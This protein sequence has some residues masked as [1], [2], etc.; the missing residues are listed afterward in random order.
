MG[1]ESFNVENLVSPYLVQLPTHVLTESTQTID[2]LFKLSRDP[3]YRNEIQK[4]D[5]R[6]LEYRPEN[7]AVLMA[8]DFHID[9]QGHP[10]LIEINTNASGYLFCNEL[11][12]ILEDRSA[13]DLLKL[14]FFED[15]HGKTTK[16]ETSAVIL[17]EEI[18]K[19][20]MFFEF[21][22]YRDLLNSWGWTADLLNVEDC[23]FAPTGDLLHPRTG[24]V[25]DFVYNRFCDFKLAEERSKK[26]FNSYK[27]GLTKYSP[28][29]FEYTLL[30][31]K[32][33][34]MD[35]SRPGWLEQ[36]SLL[37]D[38]L[39]IL[40]TVLIPTRHVNTYADC[41]ELWEKRKN[42]FFK[43]KESFGGKA[44]YRGKNIS[45]KA[46]ERICEGDSVAQEYVPAP[47]VNVMFKNIESEWKYDLRFYVYKNQIQL[48]VARIYQ[49]QVT[50]FN[51]LGGGFARVSFT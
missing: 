27:S 46:F 34:L 40:R 48:A 39:E 44:T 31:D 2:A 45:R 22:M 37:P 15:A 12:R 33:R 29:P 38:E 9:S 17:D 25:V 5:P 24:K 4:N 26:L 23:A 41:E 49:G 19:Q 6:A 16:T 30:A 50:N 3:N 10:R 42:L 20:K 35:W 13:L 32:Q 43:P 1:L 7:Y 21:L 51:T 8:Y 28:N 47:T 18:F 14:S 11:Y 36:F